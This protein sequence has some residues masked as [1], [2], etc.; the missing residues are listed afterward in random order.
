V[1]VIVP[2]RVPVVVGV[3]VTMIVQVVPLGTALPQVLVWAKSPVA[4]ML[5]MLKGWLPA[6]SSVTF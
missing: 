4:T 6:A 3:K 2:V 1:I 5:V